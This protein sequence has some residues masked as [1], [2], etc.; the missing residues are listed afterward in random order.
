MP[1]YSGRVLSVASTAMCRQSSTH[2]PPLQPVISTCSQIT[3]LLFAIE[4]RTSTINSSTQMGPTWNYVARATIFSKCVGGR[5]RESTEGTSC[6]GA[7]D[8]HTG[9]AVTA[10]YRPRMRRA[11]TLFPLLL[12]SVD[13]RL[14]SRFPRHSS[15]R[16]CLHGAES[17]FKT[18]NKSLTR[19]WSCRPQHTVLLLLLLIPQ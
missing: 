16:K 13:F 4:Q 7:E 15:L 17:S 19:K 8:G 18:C 6:Y 1:T 14:N 2:L 5:N 10:W 9:A 3:H 11:I 12:P